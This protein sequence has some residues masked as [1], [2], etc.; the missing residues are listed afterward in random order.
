MGVGMEEQLKSLHW[1]PVISASGER[2]PEEDGLG[3]IA[4]LRMLFLAP[5][6]FISEVK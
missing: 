5:E 4:D 2:L 6:A 3:C 1:A